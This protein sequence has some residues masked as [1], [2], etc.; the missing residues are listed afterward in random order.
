MHVR[1]NSIARSGVLKLDVHNILMR[2][3]PAGKQLMSLLD[4]LRSVGV[5]RNNSVKVTLRHEACEQRT[6]D[7]QVMRCVQT[8]KVH[9]KLQRCMYVSIIVH[10]VGARS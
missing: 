10:I 7:M 5:P 9:A 2:R 4:S 8:V 3:N 1:V 6:I